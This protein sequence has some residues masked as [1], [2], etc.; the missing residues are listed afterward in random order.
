MACDLEP[1]LQE[2]GS[3]LPFAE[4]SDLR[5]ALN[6]PPRVPVCYLADAARLM[7]TLGPND[8]DPLRKFLTARSLTEE[9]RASFR[10]QVPWDDWTK[11]DAVSSLREGA[12]WLSG[13]GLRTLS[14]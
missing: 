11:T 13:P 1:K 14:I 5:Q 8:L 4:P 3:V 7:A 12:A 6:L 2:D 10:Q 9:A